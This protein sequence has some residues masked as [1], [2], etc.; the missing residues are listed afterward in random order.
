MF[1]Q[2][3]SVKIIKMVLYYLCEQSIQLL[4]YQIQI[5]NTYVRNKSFRIFLVGTNF[6]W[7]IADNYL[8]HF[9]NI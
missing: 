8:P 5:T 6:T 7:K 4:S 1:H 9:V 3:A 2:K